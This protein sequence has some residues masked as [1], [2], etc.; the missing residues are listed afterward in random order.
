MNTAV[1]EQIEHDFLALPQAERQTII[2]YGAALRLADLNKRLFLAESKLR[3]FQEKHNT[4]LA[5]LDNVGLP[6]D[7]GVD[8]H[9]DFIMWHHWTDVMEQVKGDI[10]ALQSVVNAGLSTGDSGRVGD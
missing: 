1:A 9:E 4:D 7:A 8:L 6:D 2:S 10:A 5:H 3:H